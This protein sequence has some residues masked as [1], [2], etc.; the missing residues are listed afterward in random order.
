MPKRDAGQSHATS[1][2]SFRYRPASARQRGLSMTRI[3]VN[4]SAD[5]VNRLRDTVSGISP[6]TLSGLVAHAIGATLSKLEAEHG[7]PFPQRAQELKAGRPR[8]KATAQAYATFTDTTNALLPSLP[9]SAGSGDGIPFS[10]VRQP[11]QAGKITHEGH[12]AQ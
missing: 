5:L 9:S 3:T 6:V 8:K 10:E 12:H 11:Y 2:L 1:G 7:G 4:L